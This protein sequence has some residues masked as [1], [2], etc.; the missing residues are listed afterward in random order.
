MISQMVSAY[1]TRRWFRWSVDVAAVLVLVVVVA[2]VHT[3]LGSSPIATFKR[4]QQ[5]FGPI[6]KL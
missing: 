3:I 4:I 5:I 1:R 2:V 6:I